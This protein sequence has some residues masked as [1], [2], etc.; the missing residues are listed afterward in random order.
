MFFLGVM[1]FSG[2]KIVS[3]LME[4]KKGEEVYQEIASQAVL[5]ETETAV[6][7]KEDGQEET[8]TLRQIDFDALWELN[9]DII[10]W[11]E[12]EGTVVDY[13]VVQAEDNNYYLRRLLDGSYHRF[14]TLFIDYQN[15]PEFLNQNTVIY[16]HN[17]KAGTMFH[18][19]DNYKEPDYYQEHPYFMLYLPDKTYRIELFS[20]TL[21]D[22]ADGIPLNFA[23]EEEYQA[24]IDGLR[25]ESTFTSPVE[26]TTSDRM[27]TLYTWAYGVETA[28]YVVCGKLVEV[29]GGTP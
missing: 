19:L 28:R 22:G 14:G 5:P 6:I 3:Q 4:D 7:E 24:Y 8:I 2:Y 13:P 26:M 1:A 18:M 15:D 11:L 10:A 23:T 27:V 25:A 12:C 9:T 21:V 17:I 20:G 16:G 29:G